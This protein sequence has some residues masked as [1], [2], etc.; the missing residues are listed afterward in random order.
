MSTPTVRIGILG[1][2]WIAPSAVIKPAQNEVHN[3]V[4]HCV[5]ARDVA[6]AKSFANK[7]GIP[8]VHS[9]YTELINDPNIDAVYIGLPNSHHMEW[10]IKAFEAGKHVLCEKPIANNA[11]E[12]EKMQEAAEK[13]GKFLMEAFHYRYHPLIKYVRKCIDDNVLDSPITGLHIKFGIPIFS[14]SDIRYNYSL[15]GGAMMDTGCYTVNCL[16]YLLNDEVEVISATPTKLSKDDRIDQDM[17]VQLK[18]RNG[19]ITASLDTSLWQIVPK[20]TIDIIGRDNSS[21]ICV[22]NW[23]APHMLYNSVIIDSKDGHQTK[24][25]FPRNR[26]TYGYM[27]EAF[28]D[29]IL[30][31]NPSAILTD[32]R[33]A[34]KN[35][36]LIDEIYTKAGMTPRETLPRS[37]E[38]SSEN[39]IELTE[40]KN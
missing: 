22:T 30:N 19:N 1:A 14:S 33:D 2:S 23:V 36:Q 21:N 24:Q 11:Q 34:I 35:M 18:T 37:Q 3:V 10:T 29:A 39:D 5:A 26:T 31:N 6:R 4:V 27:L 25:Y 15:G 7:H 28:A 9:T 40:E 32:G 8:V 20:I 17:N 12:A 13:A 16:R 38:S